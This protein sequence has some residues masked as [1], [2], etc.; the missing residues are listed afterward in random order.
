MGVSNYQDLVAWQ[1]GMELV[2]AVY[3]LT[4]G[5]PAD[6]KFGLSNQVR[7]AAVSIPSNIAEGQGG[8]LR[9]QFCLFLRI[10][11]G[12][13]QE[14]ETQI[15]LAGRLGF[16]KPDEVQTVLDLAADVGRLVAGL[17]RSIEAH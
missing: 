15:I 12:S 5:F 4:R 14:V 2:E 6:E 8:R 16:A 17:V 13:I 9:K 10:A 7:R 3:R 11:R 1:K